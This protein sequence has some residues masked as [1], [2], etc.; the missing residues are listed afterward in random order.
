MR[1]VWANLRGFLFPVLITASV[2]V[3]VVPLPPWLLDLLLSSNIT[4]SVVILLTTVYIKRP[5]EF[6][7]FPSLLLGTTLLRLVLNVATTRLILTRGGTGPGAAGGVIEAFGEFV[8]GGQMAVGLIIFAILIAIQFLVITKG[9]T[10][11]SEVAARFALDGMP[12]RQ[13]AI[14]ADLNAGLIKPEEARRRREEVSQTADFYGAMDGASKF[15]R[16]DAI[17]GIVITLI[18]IAGGMYVGMVDQGMTAVD[19]AMVFTKLTIGDGLVTQIPAFLISL[20]SGLLVTRTSTDSDLPKEIVSQ[21]FVHPQAM[22]VAALFLSGLSFTGLPKLPLMALGGGLTIIALSLSRSQQAKAIAETKSKQ[23]EAAKP[24]PARPEDKLAIDPMALELGFG[25]LRL[26]DRN[27]GGELLDRVTRVRDNIAEELGIILPKVR[28]RD[29]VRLDQNQYQIRIQDVPV[30]WG[31]VYVDGLLAIDTGAVSSPVPGLP[32]EDPAFGL[33]AVWIDAYEKERA[34]ISGYN[35]VDP[36][37]VIIT[38]LTEV[39]RRNSDELLSRQA[40]HELLDNLKQTA[41]KLVDELVPDVMKVA[42]IHQV[43]CNLLHERIPVR[44]LEAI[45]EALGDYADKTKDLGILTEYARHAL[46]RTI[47]QQYRDANR[48]MPVLTL[49]PAL[50]DVIHAGVHHGDRGMDVKLSPQV[51]EAIAR[52]I[53]ETMHAAMPPGRHPIVLVSPHIRAALRQ[54]TEAALPNL[55]VMSLNETTRD[56]HVEAVGQVGIDVLNRNRQTAKAG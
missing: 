25:L 1:S 26:A 34:E 4:I 23:T 30:A 28:V 50:E 36:T 54:M 45:L 53:A 15:V 18:N 13:M 37:T 6:S 39:V 38:H 3:I 27:S 8:A 35:V 41:P 20:A 51:T 48:A 43:L 55:I 17:A 7:V 44:N 40:V 11:I 5:L 14:D 42:Q 56:T 21:V 10:R 19:A 16:G 46:S 32:A 2:L 22:G 49:D 29:N 47:C 12:G 9:A 52:G 33:P 24:A 31:S